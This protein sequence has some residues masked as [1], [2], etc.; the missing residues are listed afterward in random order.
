MSPQDC[1]D[2][3][4][5]RLTYTRYEG[6]TTPS[7]LVD[8]ETVGR[9]CG[10]WVGS[11]GKFWWSTKPTASRTVIPSSSRSWDFSRA[12][13]A[14]CSR[15][16]PCR[17]GRKRYLGRTAVTNLMRNLLAPSAEWR[18]SVQKW[19]LRI[20]T[21]GVL[22][23][24]M[25]NVSLALGVHRAG[26]CDVDVMNSHENVT[27]PSTP[28][29]SE[30]V[31]GDDARFEL[32]IWTVH[33]GFFYHVLGCPSRRMSGLIMPCTLPII[34]KREW[35]TGGAYRGS[36][37]WVRSGIG[38]VFLDALVCSSARPITYH[39]QHEAIKPWASDGPIP[40]NFV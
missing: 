33:E 16:P 9:T 6:I 8:S 38:S 29:T 18:H 5:R 36:R 3:V 13:T 37:S 15:A 23:T 19:L 34:C 24:L 7:L 20:E 26:R 31:H 21:Q 35:S 2:G 27:A 25:I 40:K 1:R 22:K 14:F 39:E 28:M 11:V 17:T 10:S 30:G 32:V 12:T 4:V